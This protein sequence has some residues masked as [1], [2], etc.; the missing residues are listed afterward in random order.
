[1]SIDVKQLGQISRFNGVDILQSKHFIKLYN[2]TYIEKIASQ[3]Q[4]LYSKEPL[5][6]VPVPI[7]ATPD[8][9][10]KIESTEQA[11]SKELTL[12]E[13][14]YRFTYRQGIGKLIYAMIPSRRRP[15]HF[16]RIDD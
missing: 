7:H 14:E 4:W 16:L 13:K 11:S 2:K 5:S 1:M 15:V 8:Y 3:H 6:K 12:L 9:Q 10:R